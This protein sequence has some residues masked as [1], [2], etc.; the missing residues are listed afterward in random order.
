MSGP[1][2]DLAAAYR[3]SLEKYV[4]SER[5]DQLEEAYTLGRQAFA[6]GMTILG[7]VARHR[8]A[9]EAIER[10]PAPPGDATLTRT[11]L[12]FLTEALATFEMAQR[13]YWETQERARLERERSALRDRL[14][15]AYVTV[16]SAVELPARLAAIEAAAAD[17]VGAVAAVCRLVADDD[18]AG[19]QPAFPIR[20]PAG[21][22]VAV[23]RVD[24]SDRE[25]PSDDDRYLLTE[26]S[27]MAGTAI[28]T[29]RQLAHERSIA[30][31]LQHD[32]LPAALPAVSGLEVAVR[33]LPGEA[34]SHAGG[35]WYDLFHLDGDRIGLVIGDVT[36][37]GVE[38]A[39]AMGQLR[40]AVLAYALAGFE[41]AAVIDR[42]DMLLDRLGP[43]RIATMVYVIAD[44]ATR[45]LTVANAGHPPPIV[46]EPDGLSRPVLAG[47]TRLLGTSP[48][49]GERTQGVTHLQPGSQLLL[50]TDGLVEPL[51]RA[52]VDGIAY[53]HEVTRGFTGSGEQLCD[54][55]LGE[56]APD[57]SSDD[58]CILVATLTP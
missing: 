5:E 16:D 17:L 54:R 55:V 51:E 30:L 42:V 10:R 58:I 47:H 26:F 40:I 37:H 7:L 29:A 48:P 53:L 52:D 35:D 14:A 1:T 36:G 44:P 27:H 31:M 23:L 19:G 41:P 38:A 21:D 57:G 49:A 22:T 43:S 18:P 4:D 46:I 9:V 3:V 50:Y 12:E 39:A 25:A 28:E 11:T 8:A 15:L 6:D 32:L 2:D 45:Q 13:G 20:N 56:L 33:Y 24:L 34:S